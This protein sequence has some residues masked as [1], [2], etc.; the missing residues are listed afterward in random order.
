[1]VTH[2]GG[3]DSIVETTRNLPHIPGGKNLTY[4]QFNI[5]LTAIADFREKG[6]TDPLYARLADCCGA[7]DGLW[8]SAAEKILL[9]HFHVI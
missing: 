6:R 3:L 1:M 5:P 8:N 4:T 7:H 9:R 2:V